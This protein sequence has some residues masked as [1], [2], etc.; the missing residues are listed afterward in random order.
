[1]LDALDHRLEETERH[2][3]T[4]R[5]TDDLL[6]FDD[7]KDRLWALRDVVSAELA[8]VR[9]RLTKPKSR[10]LATREGV[11]F[12]GFRFLPGLR[13][14]VLGT[15]KRRFEARRH[16]WRR[17]RADL[18]EVVRSTFAWYQFSREG[19]TVGLRRVWAV[20]RPQSVSARPTGR[21]SNPTG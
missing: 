4:V 5:Y 2:G 12:C 15:T 13:P 18:S 7:D 14:R 19:N 20:R 10:L 16:R 8:L 17:Q 21:A 9:L 1:M 6:I 3:A 11:S